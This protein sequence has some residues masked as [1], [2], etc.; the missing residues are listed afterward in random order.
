MSRTALSMIFFALLLPAAAFGAKRTGKGPCTN[1][2]QCRSGVCVEVNGDAYC[3]ATCGECPAGMYCDAQ[4]FSAVGMKVCLRGTAQS[5][6]KPEAPPRLPCKTDKQCQ[7]AL[8]CAQMMGH[9]DCALPCATNQQ[10]ATPEIM[11]VKMDFLACQKDQ[12]HASR[13][14]CLPKKA[15]LANPASCMSVDPTAMTG[16]VQGLMKMSQGMA[17][18]MPQHEPA[19]AAPAPAPVATAMSGARFAKLL[20]QVKAAAFED[21][22]QT[23]LSTAARRNWFTCDQLGQIVEA[24]AFGDEKVG[25]VQVIAPRLVDKENSHEVLGKFTFDDDRAAAAQILNR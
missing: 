11:G 19:P 21:D 2:D 3:S 20:A 10:C 1:G 17:E 13:K 8:I 14:A 9:R 5:P 7:G 4:L 15:C 25:A 6:V 23:V 22:R 16:A 18:A 24:I 12:G